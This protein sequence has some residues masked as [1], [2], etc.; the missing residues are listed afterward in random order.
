MLSVLISVAALALTGLTLIGLGFLV[1]SIQERE[2]RATRYA[3]LQLGA[4]LILLLAFLILLWAGFFDT[5]LGI[6]LLIGGCLLYTSD[7]AD[8]RY[9][10]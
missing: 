9:R 8:D 3:V 10:V 7:A 5:T 2:A 1:S 4:M 6:L